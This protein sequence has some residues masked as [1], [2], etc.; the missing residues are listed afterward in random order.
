M[1]V[2]SLLKKQ[3]GSLQP[4]IHTECADFEPAHLDCLGPCALQTYC[5]ELPELTPRRSA[6][7]HMGVCE[8]IWVGRVKRREDCKFVACKASG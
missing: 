3:P 1:S 6:Y 8:E 4:S 7:P 5:N 2:L